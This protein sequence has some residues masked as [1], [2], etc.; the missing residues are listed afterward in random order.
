MSV[1]HFVKQYQKIQDKCLVAQDGQDFRT[2]DRARRRWSKYPIERH[3]ASVYTKNLFYRFSKEFEKTAE[4]DVK[5]E[6]Q[7]QYWLVLNNNFVYGYGKRNYLVTALEE[8]ESY[9]CECSKVDRDGMLCCHILKVMTRLGVKAIPQWYILKRWTQE[10]VPDNEGDAPNAHVQADFIARG[11]PLNNKKTVW[12]TNLS[13][14]FAKLAV[15]GCASKEVYTI[16]DNHIKQIRIEVDEVKKR[17]KK[18]TQRGRKC[19]HISLNL[20]HLIVCLLVL[21]HLKMKVYWLP[22]QLVRNKKRHCNISQTT[23][24]N[25]ART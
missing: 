15:E 16:M 25:H 12:F 3:A 20:K 7:F 18:N 10:A 9:C 5:P 13:T 11:M 21:V 2:D 22:S 1:L 14:S 19:K 6:G 24:P 23:Q 8:E 17:K 4:Y